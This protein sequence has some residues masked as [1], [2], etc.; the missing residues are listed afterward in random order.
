[1]KFKLDENVPWILKNINYIKLRFS[2]PY[3]Q[4]LWN[5]NNNNK[6]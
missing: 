5:N 2:K 6:I 4:F 1:V 3:R